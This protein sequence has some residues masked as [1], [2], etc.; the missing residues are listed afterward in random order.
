MKKENAGTPS[1]PV[2]KQRLPLLFVGVIIM[3]FSMTIVTAVDQAE[4]ESESEEE[5]VTLILVEEETNEAEVA[6]VT[7][8]FDE[9]TI[10]AQLPPYIEIECMPVVLEGR[11]DKAYDIWFVKDG[12]KIDYHTDIK[13]EFKDIYEGKIVK[14]D[15]D[16]DIDVTDY[17]DKDGDG[18]SSIWFEG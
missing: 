16:E 11:N 1:S 10:S 12:E 5:E 17:E 13:I 8:D 2:S 14:V 9:L 15:G 6:L 18:L 7:F 4:N 3:L